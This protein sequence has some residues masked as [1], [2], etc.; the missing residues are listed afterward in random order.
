MRPVRLD[1][2]ELVLGGHTAINGQVRQEFPHL[3]GPRVFGMTLIMEQ[4]KPSDPGDAGLLS[5]VGEPFHAAGIGHLLRKSRLVQTWG[6][7]GNWW[8]VWPAVETL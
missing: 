1:H 2:R 8:E 4:D 3:R 7:G 5:P 6:S